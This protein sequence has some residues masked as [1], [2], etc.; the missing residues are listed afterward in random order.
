M[1]LVDAINARLNA[2]AHLLSLIPRMQLSRK[3]VKPPTRKER[4]R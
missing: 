3:K 1:R 2:L 4:R